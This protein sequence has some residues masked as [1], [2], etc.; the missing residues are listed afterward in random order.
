MFFKP[1]LFV[2][3]VFEV[4]DLEVITRS[5]KAKAALLFYFARREFASHVARSLSCGFGC[6]S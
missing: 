1:L 5:R 2:H 3:H 4:V 6:P